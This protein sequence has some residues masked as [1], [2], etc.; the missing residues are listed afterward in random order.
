MT[1]KER[2]VLRRDGDLDAIDQELEQAMERL[3]G[4]NEQVARLLESIDHSVEPPGEE[5]VAEGE[6]GGPSPESSG[7]GAVGEDS[8]APSE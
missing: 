3:T 1:K 7:S 2:I 8:P 6:S 5:E 4:S